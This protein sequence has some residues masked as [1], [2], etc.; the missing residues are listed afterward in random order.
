MVMAKAARF[1]HIDFLGGLVLIALGLFFAL[2]ASGNYSIGELRRMGPGFF[3]VALGWVLA[4]LGVLLL[5]SSLSGPVQRVG[6]IA[7]RPFVTVVA[8]LS[9][10]ALMVERT[11]MIPSTIVLT[12][13]VALAER[14]FRPVR[15]LVLSLVLAGVAVLIFSWGLGLPIPAVRWDP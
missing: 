3:P 8:G 15:T 14:R 7:W 9:V 11:G 6:G 2:Y 10:F 5:L 1:A 4:V 12:V 13:I